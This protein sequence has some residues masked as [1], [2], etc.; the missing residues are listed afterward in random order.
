MKLLVYVDPSQRGQWALTLARDLART[1][2]DTLVLLA[3]EENLK[4]QPDLLEQAEKQ[5]NAPGLKVVKKVR[6]APARNAILDESQECYPNIT[7]FPPA[8]RRGLAR[9]IK[10]SRVKTV[11]HNAPSTVIVARQPVSEHIRRILVAVSGGPHSETT[12][13]S[14]QE[15]ASILQADLTVIHVSSNVILPFR[16]EE[17]VREELGVDQQDLSLI[18]RLVGKLGLKARVLDRQGMVTHEIPA[19]CQRGGYDLLILGQHLAETEA[20]QELA[21][22]LAE[23]LVMETPIPVLVVRPRRWA[24]QIRGR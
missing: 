6:P 4:K 7:I 2:G 18:Q 19:E 10:G 22:N 5:F 16:E 17:Q 14:S 20:G 24:A 8:G 15:I 11:V 12:L 21:E 13:L 3:I 1:P 9:L 23:I